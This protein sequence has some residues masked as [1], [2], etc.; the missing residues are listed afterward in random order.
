[1]KKLIC[2]FHNVNI[3]NEITYDC[4]LRL[5]AA[6][7]LAKEN[8]DAVFCFVGGGG[9]QPTSGA[10]TMQK[11]WVNNCQQNNTAIIPLDQSN[12]TAGN[13]EEIINFA[14]SGN[15]DEI[16]LISNQYHLKR[17]SFF[18]RKNPNAINLQAAEKILMSADINS[19]EIKNYLNSWNYKI[20]ELKEFFLLCYSKLDPRQKIVD[21]WRS[22]LRS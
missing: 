16:I 21:K 17:I 22:F 6:A 3:S 1:M 15:Y 11:F 12:N 9:L 18:T 13:V 4:S 7:E 14:Q 2:V 10:E 20:K 5:T 8:P 19:E